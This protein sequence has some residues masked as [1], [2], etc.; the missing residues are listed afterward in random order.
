M[1]YIVILVIPLILYYIVDPLTTHKN[2]IIYL[3][4]IASKCSSFDKNTIKFLGGKC[5]L[6]SA[7]ISIVFG[8]LL[9]MLY[10]IGTYNPEK[11]WESYSKLPILK[12]IQRIIVLGI[13]SALPFVTGIFISFNNIY[14][15]YFFKSS[16]PLFLVGFSMIKVYPWV[17]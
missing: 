9:S 4:N 12:R 7:M 16:F 17:L 8:F 15:H 2:R 3:N 14:M 11:W 10:T 13:V 6:D 1:A 5:F